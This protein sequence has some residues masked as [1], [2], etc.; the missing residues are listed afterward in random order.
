MINTVLEFVNAAVMPINFVFHTIIFLGGFYVAVHSRVLPVWTTTCLWYAGL[1]SL[2]INITM[3]IEWILGP[4][5]ELSYS[6][7]GSLAETMSHGVLAVTA[8][9]LLVKTVGCDIKN[10]RLRGNKET[11]TTI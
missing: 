6:H 1:S 7:I 11:P 5:F 9:L 3:C 10:K 4:Q 8:F 2:F